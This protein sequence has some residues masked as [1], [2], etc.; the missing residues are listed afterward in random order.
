MTSILDQILGHFITRNLDRAARN[1]AGF[2]STLWVSCFLGTPAL[3]SQGSSC[4]LKGL[5]QINKSTSKL[6]FTQVTHTASVSHTSQGHQTHW[7]PSLST[8]QAKL[9]T[10]SNSSKVWL[11]GHETLFICLNKRKL[12]IQSFSYHCFLSEKAISHWTAALQRQ[13]FLPLCQ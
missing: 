10:A 7:W 5:K 3:L 12:H 6:Q 11:W 9:L 8:S 4:S 1:T 13:L 2:R